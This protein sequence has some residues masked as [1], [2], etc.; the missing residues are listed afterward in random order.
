M[1]H[2]E[3]AAA[4]NDAMTAI[5]GASDLLRPHSA[6]FEHY[7]QEKERLESIGLLFDPTLFLS[8]ERREADAIIGPTFDAARS[9][10]CTIETQTRRAL[11]AA[12]QRADRSNV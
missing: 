1:T 2:E 9:F 10:L 4:L 3:A 12:M 5:R 6:L 8:R 11:E 7:A